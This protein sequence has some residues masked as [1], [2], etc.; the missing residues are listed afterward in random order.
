MLPTPRAYG[1]WPLQRM[2]ASESARLRTEST[3]R[4]E[5]EGRWQQLQ[6]L[7]LSELDTCKEKTHGVQREVSVVEDRVSHMEKT[8]SKLD[9][10][11][12]SLQKI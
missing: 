7:V 12:G 1:H 6:D 8:C 11:S 10:I 2:K 3:L 4:E 9:S 5:L